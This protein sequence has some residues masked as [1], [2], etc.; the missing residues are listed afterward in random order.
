MKKRTPSPKSKGNRVITTLFYCFYFLLILGYAV[1]MYVLRTYMTEQLIAFETDTQP[2][3]KSEAVFREHFAEPDWGQFYDA[4][5]ITV[6]EFEGKDA[7]LAYMQNKV[8][9]D[10][11]TYTLKED[12]SELLT[13]GIQAGDRELGY[14]TLANRASEEALIP[15]WQLDTFRFYVTYDHGATVIKQDGH[16]VYVNGIPLDDRYTQEILSTTAEDYLPAGTIGIRRLQ[17]AVTGLLVAPEV[18]ILDENGNPCPIIYDDRTGIYAEISPEAEPLPDALANQAEKA[19]EAYCSYMI[20]QK[21]SLYHYFASGTDA[22]RSITSAPPWAENVVETVITS[23]SLSDYYRYTEDLFSIRMQITM[24]VIW[25]DVP[26]AEIE[27][28]ESDEEKEP[29]TYTT[30]VHSVDAIFFFENRQ[31]GWKVIAMTNEDITLETCRVRL[32]FL[33]GDTELRSAFYDSAE[34]EIYG[35]VIAPPAGQIL[36]GW[37]DSEGNLVFTCAENGKLHIPEDF[38]LTPM[39]LYPVFTESETE[40]EENP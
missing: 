29:V 22:Y 19:L 4:L 23:Q 25:T 26:L 39:T 9:E 35:P 14:F 24:R 8:G 21:Q 13:Y 16:T 36:Q 32:R 28:D 15:D 7:F 30:E 34:K 37:A 6:T 5:A 33:Y 31:S 2:S 12:S 27:N 17:Q 1:G 3:V 10:P 11:L 18:S 38:S 40:S 20:G